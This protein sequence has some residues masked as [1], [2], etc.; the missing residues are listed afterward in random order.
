MKTRHF[1]AK[2]CLN[3]HLDPAQTPWAGRPEATPTQFEESPPWHS[4]KLHNDLN[5]HASFPPPWK[6]RTRPVT[7]ATPFFTPFTWSQKSQPAPTH[8]HQQQRHPCRIEITQERGSC[9]FLAILS[10]ANHPLNLILKEKKIPPLGS[11]S[12]KPTA[13]LAMPAPSKSLSHFH[14]RP[15]TI[16]LRKSSP[17]TSRAPP[18][19]LHHHLSEPLRTPPPTLTPTTSRNQRWACSTKTHKSPRPKCGATEL[20]LRQH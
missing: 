15:T 18:P 11:S 3:P 8:P 12:Q 9:T 14:K 2:R 1:V 13:D 19:K 16:L 20:D 7:Q 6:N 10:N 17:L 4:T 5:T